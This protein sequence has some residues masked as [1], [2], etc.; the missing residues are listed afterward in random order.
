MKFPLRDLLSAAGEAEQRPP[1]PLLL[2]FDFVEFFGG[3]GRVSAAAYKLGL[4]VA[5]PL[6]LDASVHFTIRYVSAG[7]LGVGTSHDRDWQV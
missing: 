1:R 7:T 2:Y 3:S 5:P 6:D 4:S